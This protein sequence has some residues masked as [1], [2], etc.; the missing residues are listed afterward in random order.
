MNQHI[1][2]VNSHKLWISIVIVGIGVSTLLA[3]PARERTLED[4]LPSEAYQPIEFYVGVWKVKEV[5]Y[6]NYGAVI[7]TVDGT[8][9]NRWILNK[10]AVQRI[11]ITTS[12]ESVFRAIGTIT[13]NKDEQKYQ[14]VWFDN[15]S[16]AGP[17]FFKGDWTPKTRTFVYQLR[18]DSKNNQTT[19]KIVEQFVDE[20]TRLATTYEIN[21][22]S[23]VKRLEVHYT[24][25]VPCPPKIRRIFDSGL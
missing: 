21:D 19:Y 7:A 22:G 11:Y 13:W 16:T 1:S 20:E 8:E 15:R 3:Q 14:G 12:G 25:T 10:H 5:H 6:N 24:R 9:E 18:T 4:P 2:Y 23:V 17:S